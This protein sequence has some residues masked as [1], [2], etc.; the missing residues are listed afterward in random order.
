MMHRDEKRT[1]AWE[2]LCAIEAMT[3]RRFR[4]Q[5]TPEI[6]G[7]SSGRSEALV[8]T[9]NGD[10]KV[11]MGQGRSHV[12]LHSKDVAYIPKGE[13]FSVSRNDGPAEVILAFAPAAV[14]YEPFVKRFAE[15]S[16]IGSG[17]APYFRRIYNM[18]TEK[19]RANRFLGGF[20]E[21]GSGNWTSFPPH[22][23]DG[24]P[25]IYV[26]YALGDKFGV[27]MVLTEGQ[28]ASYVVREG[29]AVLFEKGYH[30]N[31]ATPGTGMN[32]L[33][34]ISAPPDKRDLSV[35]FHPS[36]KEMQAGPT[37]LRTAAPGLS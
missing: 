5:A 31:V 9:M 27:Q 7:L 29:D 20:V 1:D 19:D 14:K 11:S 16:P 23:H 18:V 22:R 28:D 17:T 15:T 26:Y 25:E 6:T 24:K 34:V 4:M 35:E 30:P 8:I 37:H 36:F 2:Q 12:Q 21:G 3:L 32:F 10:I 33:W 13:T